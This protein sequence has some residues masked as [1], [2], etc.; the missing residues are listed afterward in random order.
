MYENISTVIAVL[1]GITWNEFKSVVAVC[2][3]HLAHRKVTIKDVGRQFSFH[4]AYIFYA[5]FEFG[6]Q[7]QLLHNLISL[8]IAVASTGFPT[9]WVHMHAPVEWQWNVC[10][11]I[12]DQA[13]P[14]PHVFPDVTFFPLCV[15]CLHA[16]SLPGPNCSTLISVLLLYPK[17]RQEG[18]HG[19]FH[20]IDLAAVRA[21]EKKADISWERLSGR[22]ECR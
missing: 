15:C 4:T 20:G 13:H 5:I 22:R 7:K 6:F 9:K 11:I 3:T 19:G 10:L 12:Q 14:H 1:W 2:S 16:H 21:T 8:W 18:D 17:Q